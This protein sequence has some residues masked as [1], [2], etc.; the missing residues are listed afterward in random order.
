MYAQ[1]LHEC[2]PITEKP[3]VL[4]EVERPVAAAEEVLIKGAGV[5]VMDT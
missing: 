5:L 4:S 2:K 1:I 3:L